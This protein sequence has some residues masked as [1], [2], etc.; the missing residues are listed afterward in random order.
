M[1]ALEENLL[2]QMCDRGYISPLN[3]F[4]CYFSSLLLTLLLFGTVLPCCNRNQVKLQC[5]VWWFPYAEDFIE[6]DQLLNHRD[7]KSFLCNQCDLKLSLA[8]TLK[9]QMRVHMLLDPEC[10]VWT[11][12]WQPGP[13]PSVTCLL[14]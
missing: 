2:R 14:R 3:H 8:A 5:I 1:I 11:G 7:K 6:I 10:L 13:R 9:T 12:W 4:E